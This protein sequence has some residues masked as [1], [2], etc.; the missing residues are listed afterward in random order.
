MKTAPAMVT[1]MNAKLESLGEM[2][3]VEGEE[4]AKMKSFLGA[5]KIEGTG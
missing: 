3:S 5:S 1:T 4:A 2:E